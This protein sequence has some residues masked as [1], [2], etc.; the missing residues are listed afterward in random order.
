MEPMGCGPH[1]TDIIA[2]RPID[3]RIRQLMWEQLPERGMMANE[4]HCLRRF[5]KTKGLWDEYITWATSGD[6]PP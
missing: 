4:M 3:A 5:L 2:P 6:S 1:E